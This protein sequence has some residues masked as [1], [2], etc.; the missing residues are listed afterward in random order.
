LKKAK[1][2]TDL[3]I[4]FQNYGEVKTFGR[5]FKEILCLL[6]GYLGSTTKTI[7]MFFLRDNS[8]D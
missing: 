8:N 7:L 5:I 6:T 2:R 3:K 4:Q 1:I